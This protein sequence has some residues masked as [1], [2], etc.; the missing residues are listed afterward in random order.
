MS[1]EY[2]Y[3]KKKNLKTYNPISHRI[4]NNNVAAK[5]LKVLCIE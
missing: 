2:K 1:S 4:A 3:S 5:N